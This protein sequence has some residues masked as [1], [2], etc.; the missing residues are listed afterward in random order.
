M[1]GSVLSDPLPVSS[2]LLGDGAGLTGGP[3]APARFGKF[4]LDF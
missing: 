4:L 3:Q 2:R 1:G